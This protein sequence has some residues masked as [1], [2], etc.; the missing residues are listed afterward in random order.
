MSLRP[1]DDQM[2][3]IV[4]SL[5]QYNKDSIYSPNYTT[6]GPWDANPEVPNHQVPKRP[7]KVNSPINKY[8]KRISRILQEK[9]RSIISRISRRMDDRPQNGNKASAAYCPHVVEIKK[10]E[11]VLLPEIGGIKLITQPYSPPVN[12]PETFNINFEELIDNIRL[13]RIIKLRKSPTMIRNEHTMP[14]VN[15]YAF[16]EDPRVSALRH[17]KKIEGY[18]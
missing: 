13:P 4:V 1:Y 10:T 14:V 11:V 9:H 2:D 5:L 12:R 17:L 15:I 18:K 3:T 16:G 6:I 8:V 7:E